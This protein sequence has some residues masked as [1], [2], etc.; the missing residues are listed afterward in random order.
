MLNNIKE[1]NAWI[2]KVLSEG[3]QQRVSSFLVDK[4]IKYHYKRAI[5][6]PPAKR[7]YRQSS[8]NQRNA[9]DDGPALSAGLV[10]TCKCDLPGIWTSIAKEP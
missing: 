2:Q 9:I 6:G 7:H 4:G 8:A 5:I 1:K 3:V 10:A